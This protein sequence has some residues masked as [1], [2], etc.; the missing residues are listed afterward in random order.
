MAYERLVTVF[1]EAEVAGDW[2]TPIHVLQ[3]LSKTKAQVPLPDWLLMEAVWSSVQRKKRLHCGHP[4]HVAPRQFLCEL[5]TLTFWSQVVEFDLSF[6][7]LDSSYLYAQGFN[8]GTCNS[9]S[10][11]LAHPQSK[12]LSPHPLFNTRRY[13]KSEQLEKTPHHPLV[14]FFRHASGY[15][16]KSPLPTPYFDCDWYRLN[17]LQGI[18]GVNPLLHYLSHCH[19][20][21]VQPGPH[22]NNDYVRQTQDLPVTADPLTHYLT[23]LQRLGEAFCRQGFSPC[24]YFDRTYYLSRYPD[25]NAAMKQS[26]FDPFLHFATMSTA[27]GRWGHP[28]LCQHRATPE[29]LAHFAAKKRLAVLVLGMHRSGTS[30]LTRVIS[31]LGMDLPSRLMVSDGN[32]ETGYWESLELANIHDQILALLGSS[33]DGVLPVSDSQLLANPHAQSLLVNYVAREFVDSECFVLKDPRMCKLVP[34]WL[35]ALQALNV[36]IKIVIAFRNPLEVALSLQ[37]RNEFPLEKSYLLWL[38]HVLEAEQHSRGIDRCIVSYAQL[39]ANHKTVIKQL[40]SLFGAQWPIN[41]SD[42]ALAEISQFI[43]SKHYHQRVPKARVLTAQLPEWVAKTYAAL[44]RL[45]KNGSDARALRVLN[46]ISG[47]IQQADKI[48]APVIANMAETAQAMTGTH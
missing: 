48:Y 41:C 27:E 22:F 31:L 6:S 2:V 24:P 35:S 32:N 37:K 4:E 14:H 29:T 15:Q 1:D 7:L 18:P 42:A 19:E 5:E 17:Y 9:L 39:L 10:Q 8:E 13:I 38:R 21:G 25:I 28:W 12:Q 3:S 11:F 40:E 23:E 45:S 44:H 43:D 30:V 33:W 34:L 26:G 20:P 46:K 47:A 36:Q 16:K